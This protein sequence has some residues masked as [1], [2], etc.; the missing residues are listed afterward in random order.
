M[1]VK[2]IML[3]YSWTGILPETVETLTAAAKVV[4]TDWTKQNMFY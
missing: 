2:A 4:L 1:P 3:N